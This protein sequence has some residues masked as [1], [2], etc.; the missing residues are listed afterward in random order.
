MFFTVRLFC[1]FGRTFQSTLSDHQ[2]PTAWFT[3]LSLSCRRNSIF[4]TIVA[5]IYVRRLCLFAD[6]VCVTNY[7]MILCLQCDAKWSHRLD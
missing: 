3:R 6:L 2:Q 7:R 4:I 1:T 5:D